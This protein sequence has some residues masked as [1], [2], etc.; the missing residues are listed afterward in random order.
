[1]LP[2]PFPRKYTIS[3]GPATNIRIRANTHGSL[4][5]SIKPIN[6]PITSKK[7]PPPTINTQA[8]Q[9]Q[10]CDN[11]CPLT[12][13]RNINPIKGRCQNQTPVLIR[14]MHEILISLLNRTII[15]LNRLLQSISRNPELRRQPPQRP[16]FLISL[17]HPT[18][19]L[20]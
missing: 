19:A 18:K 8:T 2:N 12:L 7:Q 17:V 6:F 14:L 5:H 13:R 9:R 16:R 11:L 10:P 20:Q 15:P 1:M 4:T 3:Q